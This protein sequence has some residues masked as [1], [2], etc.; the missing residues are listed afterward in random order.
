MKTHGN[1]RP[2]N[3]THPGQGIPLAEA[4]PNCVLH[5]VK[6]VDQYVLKAVIRGDLRIQVPIKSIMLTPFPGRKGVSVIGEPGVRKSS[7]TARS[8]WV[9]AGI[10]GRS[11]A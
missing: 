8:G 7:A 11:R 9:K 4:L 2:D 10:Q 6:W 5:L 1:A 3:E